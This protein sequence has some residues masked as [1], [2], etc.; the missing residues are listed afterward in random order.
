MN[1]Q[2]F[3]CIVIHTLFIKNVFCENPPFEIDCSAVRMGQYL[4]PDPSYL[5]EMVDPK[6]Q[7]LKGCTKENKAKVRCITANGLICTESGNNTF[8]K[9]M[10]CKWT[11]GYS[12]ETT[13]LLSIFLGMFGIDRFYLGYPAIGLAKFCTLGF[14]FLGQLVDIIL[15]STQTVTPADGSYYVMPYYGPRVEVIKS[16]NNTF[17]LGQDDW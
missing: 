1:T 2:I 3:I 15:I 4:C 13:L 10:P 6:T 9:E 17:R 5:D 16:D 7:Q 8:Y 11:N 12:F 14:M